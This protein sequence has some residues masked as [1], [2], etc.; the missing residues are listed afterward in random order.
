MSDQKISESTPRMLVVVGDVMRRERLAH[1]VEGRGA[2]VAV[3]H[4]DR[5]QGQRGRSD[6]AAA[7]DG[8]GPVIAE[9]RDGLRRTSR[10]VARVLGW[11][12]PWEA[13]PDP[14]DLAS[15]SLTF[16]AIGARTRASRR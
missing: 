7:P 9:R 13:V 10:P 12:L 4:A 5:C 3:H 14:V 11:S 6:R 8:S 2:D 1:R 16:D 15:P